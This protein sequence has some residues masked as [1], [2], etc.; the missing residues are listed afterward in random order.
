M[1]ALGAGLLTPPLAWTEGLPLVMAR[2]FQLDHA[3]NIG[4]PSWSP[5]VG[6]AAGSRDPRRTR[7]RR[8]SAATNPTVKLNR[9]HGINLEFDVHSLFL[10]AAPPTF[11]KGGRPNSRD[12]D[13]RSSIVRAAKCGGQS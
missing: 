8:A 9:H 11:C 3:T 6:E 12:I 13:P 7:A 5:A 2:L 10:V 1:L 4:S